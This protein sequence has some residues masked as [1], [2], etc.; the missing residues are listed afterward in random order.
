M[1][2]RFCTGAVAAVALFTGPALAAEYR[3]L[4]S[5][6]R[7]NPA[8]PVLAEPFARNV[9][10]AS[11]GGIKLVLNG[12]E[13][14]PP[15]EQLQ[16]VVAGAFQF[17]FTHGIYHYGTTGIAVGLDALTGTIEERRASG[18][19]EALDKHYQRL[20]LKLIAAAISAKDGYGMVLKAPVGPD[21]DLKGRKIRGT[22][23]YHSL[24]RSLGGAPVV[25]PGGEVYSALEKGVVDG[26][27]WPVVG[28]V[29]MRW[30]EVAKQL[31]QPTYGVNHY[32][33]LANLGAWNRL[34]DAD[35]KIMIDEG[36]K[37]EEVWYKEY[38]KMAAAEIKDLLA[39][40]MTVAKLGTS[41][42]KMN[43]IWA[44]GQWELAEKKSPAEAKELRALAKAK[45]ITN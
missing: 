25:L 23:S 7:S 45:G 28:L 42:A 1:F 8:I 30:Y 44:A 2:G 16:P 35:K 43:E 6:D 10:K 11:N 20:G 21:G 4:T 24:I 32:L 27:T 18:I 19:F 22:P 15:F 37:L 26:A 36:R 5:W 17:L 41:Q 14:V 9:E 33:F 29:G 34:S 12:P 31:V 38:E 13:T 39:K 40:G 3:M